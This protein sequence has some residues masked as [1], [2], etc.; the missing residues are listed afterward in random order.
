MTWDL[1]PSLED[2]PW[3]DAARRCAWRSTTCACSTRAIP[4]KLR[5]RAEERTARVVRWVEQRSRGWA[6]GW[7][8]PR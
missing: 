7:L 1:L 4:P 2:E 5:M 6:R 3:F 8:A